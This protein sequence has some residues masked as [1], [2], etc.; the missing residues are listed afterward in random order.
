MGAR[1]LG[2][3][4]AHRNGHDADDAHRAVQG[5][6]DNAADPDILRRLGDPAT[7]QPDMTLVNQCLGKA[8]AFQQPDEEQEAVEAHAGLTLETRQ[9]CKG[10]ARFR[11]LRRPAARAPLAA[12]CPGLAGRDKADF[13]HQVPDGRFIEA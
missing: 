7:I 12:P 11:S 5:Q 13:G 1:F 6:G 10:V 2:R 4:A 8:T 3:S 9:C